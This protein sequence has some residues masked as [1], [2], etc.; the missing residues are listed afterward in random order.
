MEVESVKGGFTVCLPAISLKLGWAGETRAEGGAVEA[1]S[2]RDRLAAAVTP[3]QVT[4]T[5][6]LGRVSMSAAELA[7]LDRGDVLCL[8]R[9]AGA[10]L[11][12]LVAGKPKFWCRPVKSGEKL[13]V[14]IVREM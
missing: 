7:S 3:A 9:P 11:E 5:V 1:A 10:N 6:R 4:C 13:A 12:M 8:E 14:E 2:R